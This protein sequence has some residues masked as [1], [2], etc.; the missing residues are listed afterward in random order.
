[1]ISFKIIETNKPGSK[2]GE[3]LYFAKTIITGKTDTNPDYALE[4]K[5]WIG[6]I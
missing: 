2:Y 3:K 6:C 1:M 5:S 4:K